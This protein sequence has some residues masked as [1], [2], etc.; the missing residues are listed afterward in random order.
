M[1]GVAG[2]V[3]SLS[4]EEQ[5]DVVAVAAKATDGRVPVIAG[6]SA[7]TAQGGA[8]L[9]ELAAKKGASGILVQA[10]AVFGRGIGQAPEIAIA[11]FREIA[12]VGVP[13]I[14]FSTKSRPAAPIRIPY[15]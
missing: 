9:T 8:K 7:E 4:S 1:N 5:G 10:P 6:L 13:I 15:C 12:A 14:V 2:E 11:Y 3:G